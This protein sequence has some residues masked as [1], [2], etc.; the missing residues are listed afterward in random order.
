M[1]GSRREGDK[2][3]ARRGEYTQ[4]G[5]RANEGDEGEGERSASK[6]T[7]RRA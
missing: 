6:R 1:H 5:A 4:G 2:D 7:G 3:E